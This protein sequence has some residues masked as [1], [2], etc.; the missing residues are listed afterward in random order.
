MAARATMLAIVAL[1]PMAA[2]PP[3]L[4]N[5]PPIE[6]FLRLESG[7]HIA[8]INQVSVDAAA[9]LLLT[10]S[11]DKTAR[12]WSRGDGRLIQVLRPPIGTGHEGKLYAGEGSS[13]CPRFI[14]I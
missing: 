8:V 9:Q 3:A 5:D 4:A 7:M 2:N 11:D 12:V 10:V 1:G 13:R 14:N 6:P